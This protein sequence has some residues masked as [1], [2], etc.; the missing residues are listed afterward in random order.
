MSHIAARH[1]APLCGQFGITPRSARQDIANWNDAVQA[2][3]DS[4]EDLDGI[5]FRIL[6]STCGNDDSVCG[7]G[8][9]TVD[10]VDAR[11][12]T[13]T[14]TTSDGTGEKIFYYLGE[15]LAD[16]YAD[17][18]D[19]SWDSHSWTDES[20]NSVT[21][22]VLTG[23]ASDGTA[24]SNAP[25]D[26]AGFINRGSRTSGREFVHPNNNP[27]YPTGGGKVYALS[28]VLTVTVDTAPDFGTEDVDDQTWTV[29]T[30]I[31]AVTL[32]TATG[33]NDTLSYELTPDI[34]GY[35]LTLTNGVIS[36]TPDTAL[37]TATEFT[38]TV[39]DGDD[40]TAGTDEDTVT[41]MVT[42]NKGTQSLSGGGDT[43]N[44]TFGRR[45]AHAA[46][47]S[48]RIRPP[49]AGTVQ[50]GQQRYRRLHDSR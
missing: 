38:W 17:L 44:I 19:G 18:Y 26:S 16:N 21:G 32:P 50:Y 36:G 4:N 7:D 9:G 10:G 1:F 20:G 11:D 6:G 49:A 5:V 42:I 23:T 34:T 12:N 22:T 35:G 30:A 40:N 3:A 25:L 41:F 33:G 2:V 29:G 15:K 47:D 28:G 14:N 48:R 27:A 8:S 45:R 43:F 13:S 24:N 39:S 37:T 31:T 46:H